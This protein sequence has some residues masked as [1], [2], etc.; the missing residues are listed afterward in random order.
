[1]RTTAYV[2]M[3]LIPVL[4]G[5]TA[6]GQK[7]PTHFHPGEWQIDSVTTVAGGHTIT[8]STRLCAHKQVDFWKVAQADLSCKPPKTHAESSD[9]LRVRVHCEY[10]GEKLHSEIRSEA[11]ET[12]S[13]HGDSFA[14][15]GTTRTDTVYHGV[16][17][18][19]TSA[20]L[21]ATA[22]RIGDCK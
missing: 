1:M 22:H 19:K 5:T 4:S 13:N 17:P 12:F 9:R 16:Q 8:S 21:H 10:D 15:D 20:K 11:V 6:L 7:H 18:K 14:L 2:L 3:I